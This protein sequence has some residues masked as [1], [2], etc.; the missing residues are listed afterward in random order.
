MSHT[1]ARSGL[2]M[3]NATSSRSSDD[4][5]QPFGANAMAV[6]STVGSSSASSNFES[7]LCDAS[8]QVYGTCTIVLGHTATDR[9]TDT[10]GSTKRQ[11]DH[12]QPF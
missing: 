4:T 11:L 10:L 8:N 3:E 6:T 9:H 7:E 2:S 1:A 12:N 5:G